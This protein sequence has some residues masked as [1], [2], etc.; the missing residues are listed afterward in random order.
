MSVGT[1][2]DVGFILCAPL[3]VHY[4]VEFK[5]M[6]LGEICFPMIGFMLSCFLWFFFTS[7]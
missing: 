2:E 5:K 3:Y 4:G 1:L 6:V 7:A